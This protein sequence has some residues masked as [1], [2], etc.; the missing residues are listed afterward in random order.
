LVAQSFGFDKFKTILFNI[1]FGVVNI[2]AILGGGWRATQT[3]G[4]RHF[5]PG[6]TMYPWGFASSGVKTRTWQ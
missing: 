5:H 4:D 2:I 1:P 3:Q 6:S